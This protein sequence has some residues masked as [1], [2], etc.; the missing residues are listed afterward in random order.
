MSD[1]S[2]TLPITFFWRPGCGFCR[3][4]EAELEHAGVPFERVNIWD[5]DAAAALRPFGRFRATRSCPRSGSASTA[6]VNP[7][8]AE[9]LR[10]VREPA[11]E[12]GARMT[13]A[14]PMP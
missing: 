14:V 12:P 10:E 5:D 13:H 11:A 7:S 4:L 1:T 3:R 9:V 2:T 6:L 8:V